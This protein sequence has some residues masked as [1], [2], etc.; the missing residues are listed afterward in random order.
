MKIP[1]V[2]IW[3]CVIGI[4]IMFNGKV[5]TALGGWW[6]PLI[7]SV[8]TCC[9]LFFIHLGHRKRYVL[10]PDDSEGSTYGKWILR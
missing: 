8:L 1:K 10:D 5:V 9:L 7:M 4:A 2:V 6:W 3:F